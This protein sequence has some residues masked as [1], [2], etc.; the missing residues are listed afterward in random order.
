[1]RLKISNKY[2]NTN[3][4]LALVLLI[5][6]ILT[7]MNSRILTIVNSR[8][9]VFIILSIYVLYLTYRLNILLKEEE[10]QKKQLK[11][12]SKSLDGMIQGNIFN[13]VYPICILNN[14]GDLVWYNKSFKELFNLNDEVGSNLVSV[15]KGIAL[16]KVL[17]AEKSAAQRIKVKKFIYEVYG[18]P[19]VHDE[20]NKFCMVYFNDVTYSSEG[21]KESVMLI[22]VDNLSEVT[23]SISDNIR[24]LLIAEIERAINNYGNTLGAMIKK[25]DNNKYV[26]SVSDIIIDQEINKKFGIL[27]TIRDIDLG[28]EMEVTLSIGVGRGGNTP[29]K[30]YRDATKAIELALGRGG[31][32]AVVKRDSEI[33]FFGGNTKELEKRTR[34]RARVVAHALKELIYESSKVYIMGHKN[35]DMDCFGAAF[36]ISSVVRKLGKTSKIVLDNDINAIDFFIKRIKGKEEYNDLFISSKDAKAQIDENTLIIIVDVHS[37]GYVLEKSLIEQSKKTVIID[38]HRRSPDFIQGA[39]LTYVEVYA[40]ST[41]ELVAEMVQYM[42]DKPKINRLEAEGLLAGIFMDTKNFTFK[43]GVRTFEAASFLRKLGADTIEVKKMFSNNLENYIAKAE[44]I[45]SAKVENNVAIAVCPPNI[46]D[47]VTAAQ[48]ADELLNITGIQASFVFVKIEN[49]ISISGRSLGDINVQV[50]LE[51]LGGGGHMTMA[52]ARLKDTSIEDAINMLKQAISKNL[53]EGDK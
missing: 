14:N 25:Y 45:K 34:V 30:N 3:T 42:L 51:S 46:T 19:L 11:N 28:N 18:K 26:L 41:S 1:M 38:H 16:D 21:T 44:I 6:L 52:G 27:D 5:S 4:F 9:I 47:L 53:R 43:T 31:D 50:I 7:I 12:F 15:V 24:P 32:Q 48:A 8:I 35:P 37:K 20:E 2:F 29:A 10:I 23:D 33:S 49:D 36:G 39:I 17:K 22:E 40:S 13:L